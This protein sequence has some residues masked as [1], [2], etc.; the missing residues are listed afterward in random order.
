LPSVIVV[1]KLCSAGQITGDNMAHSP[2]RVD[3]YGYKHTIRIWNKNRFSTAILATG[4]PLNITLF[5]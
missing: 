1:E 3:N 2:S 5:V 4:K